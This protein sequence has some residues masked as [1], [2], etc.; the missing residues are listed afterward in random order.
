MRVCFRLTAL[1]SLVLAGSLW[2]RPVSDPVADLFTPR[3]PLPPGAENQAAVP[4]RPP[5]NPNPAGFKVFPSPPQTIPPRRPP[6]RFQANDRVL[7]LGDAILEAEAKYGYIET[8]MAIQDPTT[9]LT[10]R[11]LSAS[12]NN[13]LRDADPAAANRDFAWLTNLLAEVRALDPNVVVLSYGTA[14][15]LNGPP[16]LPAFTNVYERVIDGLLALKP[17]TPPR[18]V[19]LSPLCHEPVTGEPME[20]I[21]HRV[22]QMFE[23]AVASWI[24]S[25]NHNT[26]FVDL[27]GLTRLKVN[28]ALKTEANGESKPRLTEDGLRPT[29]YGQRSLT[30]ALDRGLRWFP[31][32]WRFGL[33]A[34][35]QWREGGFGLKFESHR[36]SDHDLRAVF[37]EERLPSPPLPVPIADPEQE[38]EPHCYIQL[39]DLVPG[40]YELRMD[41]QHVLTG[42][43]EDWA[44]YEVI[45]SGPSWDQAEKLRQTIVEKNARWTAWWQQQREHGPGP[46][47]E[48]TPEILALE[49]VISTLKR[50]VKHAYEVVRVGDV[51]PTTNQ[52]PPTPH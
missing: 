19:L 12:P 3:P 5:E 35:N 47:G 32:N 16:N 30:F 42:T 38:Y 50:P 43:H 46:L 25:T 28:A 37:T 26:D 27:F 36:R 51:A 52:P 49:K 45:A 24:L 6:F 4:L 9:P 11:N 39:R 14:A 41:G 23:F 33:L 2:S 22:A 29:A 15:A 10:F 31:N 18:L 7:F 40:R 8:R 17:A 13:R 44:R 20:L 48:P 34:N 1:A 21:A